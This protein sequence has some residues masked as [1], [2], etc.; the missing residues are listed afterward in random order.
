MI[1]YGE[2]CRC[3][4]LLMPSLTETS[5]MPAYFI[6]IWA[7]ETLGTEPRKVVEKPSWSPVAVTWYRESSPVMLYVSERDNCR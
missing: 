6:R 1:R 3:F 7:S 4:G 5:Q 2:P